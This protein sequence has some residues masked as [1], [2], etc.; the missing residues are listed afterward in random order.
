ML[1]GRG[2]FSPYKRRVR[3][4]LLTVVVWVEF[5]VSTVLRDRR[6]ENSYWGGDIVHGFGEISLVF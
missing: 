2:L 6:G 1:A 5:L 3:G 4:D